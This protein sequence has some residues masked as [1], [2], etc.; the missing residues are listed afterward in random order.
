MTTFTTE[1]IN[2]IE[3]SPIW[4]AQQKEFL[5]YAKEGLNY[6]AIADKMGLSSSRIGQVA[7]RILR[8]TTSKLHRSVAASTG[9]D[10]YKSTPIDYAR[11]NATNKRAYQ[12]IRKQHLTPRTWEEAACLL[13]FW[14]VH[15]KSYLPTKAWEE[16][17]ALTKDHT[18]DTLEWHDIQWTISNISKQRR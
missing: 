16:V 7:N 4:D 1:L 10:N 11:L 18:K 15:E 6:T 17:C 8:M 13:A 2:R 5:T 3:H 12:Y 14:R 9:D